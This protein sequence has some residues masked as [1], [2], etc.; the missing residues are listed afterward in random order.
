M[1]SWDG[2]STS[3]NT[4]T[5]KAML[6]Q[7][8]LQEGQLLRFHLL[9]KWTIW[10]RWNW[11]RG[12]FVT[13]VTF[14]DHGEMMGEWWR[15]NTQ[16]CSTQPEFSPPA[17]RWSQLGCSPVLAARHLSGNPSCHLGLALASSSWCWRK[18]PSI[19]PPPFFSYCTFFGL[20]HEPL[21]QKGMRH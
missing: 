13:F 9:T 16:K 21:G 19:P 3:S 5:W 8:R 18:P 6:C 10:T 12:F 15:M 14:C 17:V 11:H 20:I 1:P 7:R 2:S 4:N